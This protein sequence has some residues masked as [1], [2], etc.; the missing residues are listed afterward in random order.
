MSD[1]SS[2]AVSAS[3]NLSCLSSVGG[4]RKVYIFTDVTGTTETAGEISDISGTGSAFTYEL[5][6]NGGSSLT[7]TIN[8]SLEN[9][10]LFYQ[11]DLLMV[12]HKL[13]TSLRNQ[14]KLLAQNR[15][16]KVVVESNNGNQFFLGED[17]D[18]G[19][20]Q[21]GTATT[22]VSFGDASSYSITLSFFQKS[23]MMELS[24]PLTSVLTGITIVE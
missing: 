12:F 11:Q 6:K 17:F 1:Y 18:G 22:G 10:S 20:L 8:N 21:T 13:D 3:Y 19:Y 15:G 4:L 5:R 7:E 23:P 2:C 24:A 9:G 16:L 14:I